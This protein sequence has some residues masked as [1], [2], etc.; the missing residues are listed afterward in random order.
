MKLPQL[1]T[2]ER[3]IGRLHITPK[4]MAGMA[5]LVLVIISI[6]LL[7][8]A[9]KYN[10]AVLNPQGIIA[11]KQKSLL[12]FTL[13]LGVFVV[14]PVFIMLF[15]FAYRYR[16]DRAEKKKTV[17]RPDDEGNHLLEI[18]WWGIPIVIIIV[19]SILTWFSTHDL[20]PYKKLDSNKA[21][22]RVQVVSLQWKWLFMY[23]DQRVASVNELRIPA[24]R[25]IEFE[26][27]ADSPMSTFWVPSLGSQIY[28]MNG[29]T[30]RLSLEAS[31]PGTYDGTNT[32]ISGEGYSDM[33]FK[34]IATTD[35]EF[36]QWAKNAAQSN[37]HLDWTLYSQVAKPSRKQAV[38]YYMLHEPK[39]YDR[40]I[41]KYMSHDQTT[42]THNESMN[43]E[44][45]SH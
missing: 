14:V 22:L 45:M 16:A 5:A 13:L 40:I 10:I 18:I 28:A 23:P 32:N 35:E 7:F 44:G 2:I 20:D 26:I 39:L 19:L 42:E 34:V 41:A 33:R 27:T 43:H 12:M 17:Y 37:K 11:D 3:S 9:S 38:T 25:P 24:G 4:K 15:L 6:A 21:P 1:K 36:D 8:I 29:M 31:N 30:T